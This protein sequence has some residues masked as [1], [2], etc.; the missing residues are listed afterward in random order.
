M[1]STQIQAFT[2]FRPC[3]VSNW[4]YLDKKNLISSLAVTAKMHIMDSLDNR[5]IWQILQLWYPTGGK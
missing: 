4:L 2:E 3:A 1:S 5:G